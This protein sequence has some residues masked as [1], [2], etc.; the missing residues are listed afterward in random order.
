MLHELLDIDGRLLLTLKTLLFE[1]GKLTVEYN[2]GRRIKYTPPLRMYLVISIVFF[3]IFALIERHVLTN[4][5]DM[6]SVAELY[7]RIM[8]VLLPAFAILLQVFYRNTYFVS[9]LIFALHIHSFSYLMLL[10]IMPLENLADSSWIFLTIQLLLFGYMTAYLLIALKRT[11]QQKWPIT[12][13]KL[14]LISSFYLGLV[15][16]SFEFIQH[17]LA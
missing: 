6:N 16:S 1:P 3:L 12:L 2:R 11:Y 7:P 14:I 17:K 10:L 9:N 8:F 5:Q 15:L 4:H 13:I